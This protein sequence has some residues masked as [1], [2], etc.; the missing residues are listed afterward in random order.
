MKLNT[1]VVIVNSADTDVFLLLLKYHD[2]IDCRQ[3]SIKLVSGFLDISIIHGK[4]RDLC[5]NVLLSL[6][7][8]TG[9][10]TTGKF[11]G[12]SKELWFRHLLQSELGN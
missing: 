5:I 2:A 8:L 7:A 6:H 11:Q 3:L 12:I 10:D 1:M 9:C 4:L